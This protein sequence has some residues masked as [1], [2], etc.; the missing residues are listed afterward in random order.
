[1]RIAVGQ[2]FQETNT[3][4][5]FQTDL[6]TFKS[7]HLWHGD[8]LL[9]AFG[10]ARV[11]V[12]G[13]LAVLRRAGVEPVPLIAANAL[14]G[15]VVDTRRVRHSDVRSRDAAGPGRG[16]GRGSPGAAWGDVHLG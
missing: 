12:P 7:V 14:A 13:F 2:I 3:F 16:A 9:A 8:E 10:D 15:G 1:M 6:T 11:E 5:P 4:A